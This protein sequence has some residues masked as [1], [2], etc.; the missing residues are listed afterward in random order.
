MRAR[1]RL[2]IQQFVLDQGRQQAGDFGDFRACESIQSVHFSMDS[3]KREPRA[4]RA[5]SPSLPCATTEILL[6][7]RLRTGL[8]APC[9]PMLRYRR[10]Q[11]GPIFSLR[12]I[13]PLDESNGSMGK[14]PLLPLEKPCRRIRTG[15]IYA[16]ILP[17]AQARFAQGRAGISGVSLL[18]QVLFYSGSHNVPRYLGRQGRRGIGA[19]S[20]LGR[21]S[22]DV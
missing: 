21:Q 8:H 9:P 10:S 16:S 4:G 6:E 18:R 20:Q 5:I 2:S 3:G 12:R 7:L 1:S 19:D 13:I 15:R 17:E 11:T 14:S 22:A